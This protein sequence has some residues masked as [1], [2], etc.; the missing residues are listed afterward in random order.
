MYIVIEMQATNGTTSTITTTYADL[1]TAYN[2][3]YTI[4]AAAAV[5]QVDI[6]SAMIITPQA[7]LVVTKFFDHRQAQTE[8]EE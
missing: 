1:N 8:G 6:H 7:D 5:S 2:K 3:F 4:L